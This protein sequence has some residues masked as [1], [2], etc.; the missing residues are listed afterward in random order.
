MTWEVRKDNLA[1]FRQECRAPI[2]TGY[3][4]DNNDLNEPLHMGVGIN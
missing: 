1:I 2:T 3:K 4:G